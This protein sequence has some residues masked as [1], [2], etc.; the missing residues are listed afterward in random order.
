VTIFILF[1]VY[2]SEFIKAGSVLRQPRLD[3]CRALD[4]TNKKKKNYVP[5]E[6]NTA[7]LAN[8]TFLTTFLLFSFSVGRVLIITNPSK[9]NNNK[10]I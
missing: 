9:N 2:I 6:M 5:A 4:E 10:K 3:S 1:F 8:L 7:E